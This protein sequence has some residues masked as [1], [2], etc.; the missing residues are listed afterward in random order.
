MQLP[1]NLPSPVGLS[2]EEILDLLFRE[3]YGYPPPPPASVTAEVIRAERYYFG[4][5]ADVLH[6]S[7]TVSG[8]FGTYSVPFRYVRLSK[9]ETPAPAFIH[10]AFNRNVCDRFQATEEI[11]DGGFHLFS[12]NYDDITVDDGHF[13]EGDFTDGIA[14]CF[15]PDGKRP[16]DGAGKLVLWAWCASALHTYVRTLPEVDPDCISVIG[17]SRLGKTALLAGAMDPRF[18][19][20]ISNDSGASGAAL[21]RE[22][23]G[24]TVRAI[25]EHFPFWFCKNYEKYADNEDA[26]PFDQH[27]LLAANATH[28][29]YVGSGSTDKTACPENEYLSCVA[30]TPYFASVG[31]TGLVAPDRMPEVGEHFH[32]G[33]VGYHLREGA[34]FLSRFDWQN[35]MTYILRHRGK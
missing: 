18:F 12:V 30:V 21:S 19:C 2:R 31:K 16:Q 8:D 22:K 14:A 5:K 29:V 23:T 17:H 6:L 34:H 20:A 13:T 15:Y 27:Y 1:K 26:L 28:R 9:T 4:Q 35:Y 11:L 25:Y 24:E 33:H 32:E 3:E 10:L 7:L